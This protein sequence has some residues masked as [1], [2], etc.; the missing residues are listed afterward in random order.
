MLLNCISYPNSESDKPMKKSEYLL[1]YERF[2]D[3]TFALLF[4]TYKLGEN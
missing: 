2:Q 1:L 4:I 3:P